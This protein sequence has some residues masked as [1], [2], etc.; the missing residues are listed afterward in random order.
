ME[1]AIFSTAF[2]FLSWLIGGWSLLLTVLLILNFLDF[3]TGMAASWGDINSKRGFQGIIK[4]GLMWVWIVIANLIYLIL[5]EQGLEAG[6]VIPDAVTVMF[7]LN[8]IVSLS[9]NSARLGVDM[10]EPIKKALAIFQK[11]EGK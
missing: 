8:E 7:I 3:I 5:G 9:E 6:Q 4:K 10:P 2:G 1:K 11:R